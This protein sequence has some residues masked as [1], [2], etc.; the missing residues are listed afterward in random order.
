MGCSSSPSAP[1]QEEQQEPSRASTLTAI[2]P[3]SFNATVAESVAVSVRVN[4]QRGNGFPNASVSL[5]VAEGGGSVSSSSVVTDGTGQAQA[6]WVLGATIGNNRLRA[7]VLQLP[8]VEFVGVAKSGKAT[9]LRIQSQPG[10]AQIGA[11]LAVQPVVELFDVHGNRA[12]GANVEVTASIASGGGA[13]TGNAT[14]SS[15]DGLVRFTNLEITGPIGSRSLR[16]T[17]A[18][19]P[20][21]ESSAFVLMPA[22]RSLSDRPDD[23]SGAQIHFM[24]VVPSDGADRSF[25]TTPNL[26]YSVVSFQRWLSQQTGRALR[27]DTYRGAADVTFARLNKTDQEIAA[28]GAFVRDEIE[29]ELRA[30][31]QLSPGKQYAVYYDGTSTYACGGASWPPDLPGQLVAMYLRGLPQSAVPCSTAVFVTSPGE[32][33]RYWEFA[34]LHDI[35]HSLGI[36]SRQAPHHTVAY[37]GHVPEPRDL[38]YAGPGPWQIGPSGVVDIDNDDYF[39]VGTVFSFASLNSS[40]YVDQQTAAARVLDTFSPLSESALNQLRADAANLPVHP[41][42]PILMQRH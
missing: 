32:F 18:G 34:M 33:P 35:L 7:T 31:N 40:A 10:N 3:T 26:A 42:F 6:V 28:L 37:P 16:F 27:V 9:E 12:T 13:V 5:T 24:Y 17:A 2:S 30:A 19:L 36:V 20:S 23:V 1:K 25:D 22:A 11:V 4:D 38:M 21:T 29:R 15:V 8:A 14:L 39:A 41:P